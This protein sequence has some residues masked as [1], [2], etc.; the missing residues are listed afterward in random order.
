[1]AAEMQDGAAALAPGTKIADFPIQRV[2][3]RPGRFGVTYLAHAP[4]TVDDVAIK[5]FLPTEFARRDGHAVTPRSAADERPFRWGVRCFLDEARALAQLSNPH[6]VKV[7]KVLEANGTAYSVMDYVAGESLAQRL[8]Q[9]SA[10]DAARLRRILLALAQGVEAL[11]TA[12]ILHRDITSDNVILRG[13]EPVLIDFGA[14]RNAM[15]SKQPALHGTPAPHGMVFTSG[16]APVELY[17]RSGRQGPWTDLYELGAVAYHAVTGSPPP[18]ALARA[19]GTAAMTPAAEAGAE[20]F[21]VPLLAAIDWALRLAPED[22]PQSVAEWVEA[23][24]GRHAIPATTEGSP[25]VVVPLPQAAATREAATPRAGPAPA[26]AAPQMAP[27][28]APLWIGAAIVAVAVLGAGYGWHA[29]KSPRPARVAAPAASAGPAET[30]PTA[31]S[32]NNAASGNAAAPAAGE[33][34]PSETGELTLD[35]LAMELLAKEQ[36]A[37]EQA[38]Q[39]EEAKKRAEAE[40]AAH[41]QAL[42]A[43]RSREE[44]QAALRRQQE[45]EAAKQRAE[46]E[47]RR[48]QEIQQAKAAAPNAQK[49]APSEPKTQTARGN[50]TMHASDLSPSGTLTFK[51]IARMRGITLKGPDALLTPPITLPDGRQVIFEVTSDDCARIA[52][53]ITAR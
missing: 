53:L 49:P 18:D 9:E 11:H 10:P 12:G 44:Q 36:Q 50:C 21:P 34:K 48:A 43:Q 3:G 20:R 23:L 45:E 13:G 17:S 47:A 30:A 31:P 19:H 46:E 42:A 24:E 6:V 27:S 32:E 25:A 15:G 22:R 5:E 40:A 14:A 41:E 28:R 35:R 4:G 51:D 16:Y 8:R 38:R 7:R 39:Q 29:S 52:R 33:A 26:S 37:A 1:M 2:L